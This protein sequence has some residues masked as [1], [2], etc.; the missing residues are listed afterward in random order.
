MS[1]Y[2]LETKQTVAYPRCRIYRKFIKGLIEDRNIRLGGSSDFLLHCAMLFCKFPPLKQ[3]DRRNMV[4]SAAG[5]MDNKNERT[6]PHFQKS[7]KRCNP[8][9]S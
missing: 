8:V 4:Y 6:K 7:Q 5:L 3:A 9:N 2:K 1:E